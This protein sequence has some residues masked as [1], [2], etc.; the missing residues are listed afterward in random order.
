[1]PA[2]RRSVY[3]TNQTMTA[4]EVCVYTRTV[5]RTQ[6]LESIRAKEQTDNLTILN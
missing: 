3:L 6:T 1:M 2:N 5:S 4:S